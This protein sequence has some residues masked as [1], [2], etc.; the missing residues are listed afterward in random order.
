MVACV[1]DEHWTIEAT[2]DRFQVDAKTVREWRDRFLAEGDDGLQDRSS[3]PHRSVQTCES[4][5]A[6]GVYV[7]ALTGCRRPARG[8]QLARPLLG[9]CF[10]P[11]VLATRGCQ[12]S[13]TRR[14]T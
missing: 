7:S 6:A 3:R 11:R 8:S 4:D 9:H 14:R 13:A 10:R 5:L 1:L 12:T 2:A